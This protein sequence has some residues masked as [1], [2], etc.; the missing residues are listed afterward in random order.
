MKNLII[1][2]ASGFG[3]ELLQW[4]KDINSKEPTWTI[5]GFL[6]DNLD[7]LEGYECD[8]K[9]I[10]TIKD[11]QPAEDEV[12]AIAIA[13]PLIKEMVVRSLESRG[14]EFVSVI[15]PSA[16]IGSFNKVGKAIV[17]YPNSRIIVNATVGDYVTIL[18]NTSVGHDTKVGNFTTVCG[19]GSINGHVTLG[20]NVFFGTH[21]SAIPGVTIGDRSYVS[22]GSVVMSDIPEDARVFGI[23]ARKMPGNK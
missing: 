3:R 4:V 15:H 2:G 21:V 20:N 8:V 19:N 5:K 12:F 10:G 13:S 14:A 17:M 7:A 16:S 1:V 11:W 18:D 6:D 23:P 9:V 22:A